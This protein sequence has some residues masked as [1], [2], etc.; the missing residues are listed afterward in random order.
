MTR[1]RMDVVYEHHA[2]S[3]HGGDAVP[4]PV[5]D[6]NGEWVRAGDINA[7]RAEAV[8]AFAAWMEQCG[9]SSCNPADAGVF[10]EAQGWLPQEPKEK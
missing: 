5:V 9:A 6:A 10:L 8:L 3:G 2:M 7:A 1:Y 4:R